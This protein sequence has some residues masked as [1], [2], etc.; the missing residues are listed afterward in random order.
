MFDLFFQKYKATFHKGKIKNI[1]KIEWI[2]LIVLIV[3]GLFVVYSYI[4][5]ARALIFL[6]ASFIMAT[7]MIAMIF[8]ERKK[9]I[10]TIDDRIKNYKDNVIQELIKLLKEEQ[11]N[12]YNPDGL[13]WLINCCE[14]RICPHQESKSLISSIALP[15][16][17]LAYGVAINEMSAIEIV[18]ITGVFIVLIAIFNFA[19]KYAISDIIELIENPYKS[20]YESLK[21]ELEYIKILITYFVDRDV[22]ADKKL[23]STT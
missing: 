21:N 9:E 14:K 2:M 15:I 20:A 8:Y 19:Y 11:F 5:K 6:T 3:S 23:D 4:L 7:D 12:L 13:D 1:E 17:T 18:M 10:R 16:F 22:D